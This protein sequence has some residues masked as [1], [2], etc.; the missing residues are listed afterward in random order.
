MSWI[1]YI[2]IIWLVGALN[3]YVRHGRVID[4]VKGHNQDDPGGLFDVVG[5]CMALLWPFFA[6]RVIRKIKRYTHENH[7]C[8]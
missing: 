4:V 7:R 5:V 1:H 2:L 3:F 6:P 8:S